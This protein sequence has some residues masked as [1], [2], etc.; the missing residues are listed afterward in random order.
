MRGAVIGDGEAKRVS[1]THTASSA[2]ESYLGTLSL[3]LQDGF[4]VYDPS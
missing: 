4:D 2:A 1:V 3:Q